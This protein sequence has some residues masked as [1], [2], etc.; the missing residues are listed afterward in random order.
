MKMFSIVGWSGSGKTMLITRLIA[1]FQARQRAVIA[2]KG[3]HGHYDLQPEGKDTARFLRA[4]ARETYLVADGELLRMTPLAAPADL[5]S[6]LREHSRPED[7]VLLEGLSQPGIPVIEVWDPRLQKE[8]KTRPADL[9]AV[10]TA[11]ADAVSRPSFHPDDIEG[12][13]T[14]M[15]A[16]H[17]A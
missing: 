15:E 1:S 7:I 5:L 3:A 11:A 8:L 9:A 13:R 16:F 12:I 2:V 10:V 6:E 14:F 17:E 4:G